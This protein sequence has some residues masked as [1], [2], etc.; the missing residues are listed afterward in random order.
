MPMPQNATLPFMVDQ[1]TANQAIAAASFNVMENL[2]SS[3]G[4]FCGVSNSNTNNKFGSPPMPSN[5]SS[6][7]SMPMDDVHRHQ[8]G[9]PI[10]QLQQGY[11]HSIASTPQSAEASCQNQ[12]IVSP[13]EDHSSAN[14][15]GQAEH[16]SNSVHQAIEE[17]GEF[18][19]QAFEEFLMDRPSTS[20]AHCQ[21]NEPQ[22]EQ[23]SSFTPKREQQKIQQHQIPFRFEELA[24]AD[25]E[26]DRLVSLVASQ[27][28]EPQQLRQHFDFQDSL[29]S[30][31]R[32]LPHP[33]HSSNSARNE[34]PFLNAPQFTPP[35]SPTN[36]NNSSQNYLKDNS[37]GS[38][39]SG[40]TK[41]GDS[42]N[43]STTSSRSAA[44]QFISPKSETLTTKQQPKRAGAEPLSLIPQE[45]IKADPVRLNQLALSRK[46]N[47]SRVPIYKQKALLSGTSF[48]RINNG[49]ASL[50]AS[51]HLNGHQ[52][53]Q[54]DDAY[55]F[56]DEFDEPKS[57]EFLPRKNSQEKLAERT[58]KVKRKYTRRTDSSIV[59]SHD[60][61]IIKE[62]RQTAIPLLVEHIRR[63]KP[64]GGFL[65]SEVANDDN[66]A[67]S[68]D[69]PFATCTMKSDNANESAN[70][71]QPLPKL[72]I[73]LPRR[74]SRDESATAEA[75]PM[76]TTPTSV[77]HSS[78]KKHKKKKKKEDMDWTK[79][80]EC[81]FPKRKKHKEKKHKKE[82]K[83][84][85]MH[86][87]ESFDVDEPNCIKKEYP[88]QHF[89]RSDSCGEPEEHNQ[90]LLQQQQQIASH[91]N[92]EEEKANL[93]RLQYFERPTEKPK[94]G[95][96]LLAKEELFLPDCALW[97]IDNQN[98]LQKYLPLAL[99]DG[100]MGYRSSQT[101]SGW[102]E[103]FVDDYMAIKVEYIKQSRSENIVR[104]LLPIQDLFPAIN[105]RSTEKSLKADKHGKCKVV[106][107]N[108]TTKNQMFRNYFAAFTN[109]MLRHCI[110]LQFIQS[111]KESNDWNFLCTLTEIELQI[112]DYLKRGVQLEQ[113]SQPFLDS[114]NN[115]P[116]I[117]LV[118]GLDMDSDQEQSC[119]ACLAK[120]LDVKQAIQLLAEEMYDPETFE[121]KR[122][123]NADSSTCV[124]DFYVCRKC[125]ET[126]L[127]YHKAFHLRYDIF[128]AC[129]EKIEAV[130]AE[131]P[132]LSTEQVV[133]ECTAD[134]EWINNLFTEAIDALQLR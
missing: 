31:S 52:H 19:L 103:Q 112:S 56:D 13:Q 51:S 54:R 35:D 61:E 43:S 116:K 128:K 27:N 98:L 39:F 11:S 124:I 125:S 48:D 113:W 55:S 97:R 95:T 21:Q 45:Q 30:T 80:E 23:E 106:E 120:C 7:Q 77:E 73:R 20:Y 67:I 28:T 65:T 118:T 66:A 117:F 4:Q 68:A 47:D 15:Y 96:F 14:Y 110:T 92:E 57:T 132:E 2:Q 74:E 1:A 41:K 49:F 16:N 25:K 133:E 53:L 105:S 75:M 72:I 60:E 71:S 6:I 81:K 17:F 18:D 70:S 115:F 37:I 36:F 85:K 59:Q 46:S 131:H 76:P 107:A 114:L 79:S 40:G 129:E 42:F 62:S 88:S 123:A 22:Q 9:T 121:P 86:S 69:Q 64:H 108:W 12:M 58:Q 26:L 100:T 90:Q 38:T 94:R 10:Q 122:I 50:E 63:R 91:H 119:Q 3:I 8:Q 82:H 44:Q 33:P 32:Q 126:A 34:V 78:K 84:H 130:S 134:Q 83:R 102:C 87:S 93:A 109:I 104:P 89:D 101:Y 127:K 111:V 24:N 5:A 29:P 99:E